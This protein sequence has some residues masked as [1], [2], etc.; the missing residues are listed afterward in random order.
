MNLIVSDFDGTFYD[1]NY[2]QNIE[3]IENLDDTYDFV[4]AT[5]RNFESLKKD[6]KS[7]CKYYICND[8]GYI[9]NSEGNIIYNNYISDES[10]KIIYDRIKELNYDNYFFDFIDHIDINI[11]KNINKVAI[12]IRDNNAQKDMNYILNNLNDV[13]GY[14]SSNWINIISIESKKENAIETLL[15]LNKYNKTYVIGNDINDYGMLK[16]YNGYLISSIKKE[17]FK[18]LENFLELKER[19]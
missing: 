17:E 5:G 12:K 1:N 15:N 6:L 4:I 13:Y 11:D 16:K 18:T 14:L 2:L 9:L 3:F 7:K 10:I 19:L 8:G